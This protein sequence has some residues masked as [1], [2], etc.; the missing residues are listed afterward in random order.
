MMNNNM[1]DEM[2]G[3]HMDL[4]EDAYL[5]TALKGKHALVFK[6]RVLEQLRQKCWQWLGQM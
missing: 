5:K 3:K 2:V 1:T 4:L 6:A